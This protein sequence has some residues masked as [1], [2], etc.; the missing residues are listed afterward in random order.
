MEQSNKPKERIWALIYCRVSSERQVNEGNGLSSQEKRCRDFAKNKGYTVAKVFYEEGISG[1]LFGRPAMDSL[2]E[3]LESNPNKKFVI[4]FDD[5][6]RFARDVKVHIQ[7][8]TEL[9]ARGAKLECLNFNFDDSEESEYAELVL[10]AG[11]QYLRKQN[12]RQVI[13]KMKARIDAGFWPFCPPPGLKNKRDAVNGKILQPD[14]LYSEI[15]KLAIEKY[16][17]RELFTLDEFKN[18]VLSKYKEQDIKRTLSISGSKNILTEILYTGYME[19][20]P[21]GVAFKKG[22]HK[23]FISLETYN[24]VQLILQGKSKHK[25]RKDYNLDFPLRR[26]VLCNSCKRP[27]T[28]SWNKGRTKR[29][30]NYWCKTPGCEMQNK[31]INKYKLETEF[32]QLLQKTIPN[33]DVLELV[34]MIFIDEWRKS[35]EDHF[36][37]IER[38]NKE[39]WFL[40]ERIDNFMDRIGKTKDDEMISAY[41]LEVQKLKAAK[42]QLDIKNDSSLF[43]EKDLG[44]ALNTVLDVIEKPI[45]IWRKES[46]EWKRNIL[47]MYFGENLTYDKVS[48]FGTAEL[49][50]LINLTHNFGSSKIKLVEMPGI[51]PGSEKTRI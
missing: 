31:T 28:A 8:K 33:K 9:V 23:G 5:M 1:S 25:L 42:R 29:Y 44:T 51:E 47:F 20:K 39:K 13:Q 18:Y 15:Y 12:R 34:K 48:G 37:G 46:I 6:S 38:N 21:W 2:I 40:Q 24:K 3:Y 32:E 19:Y 17:H 7:L 43:S 11:N 10:A 49:S 45:V 35:K 27:M 36:A 16:E 14:G 4:I 41:E 22:Q 30:P 50:P 26:Y